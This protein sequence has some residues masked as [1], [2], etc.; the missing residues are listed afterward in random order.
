MLQCF[1]ELGI[2]ITYLV[3]LSEFDGSSSRLT[4]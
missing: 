4:E 1:K 3:D 2:L